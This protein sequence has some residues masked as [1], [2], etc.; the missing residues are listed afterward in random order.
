[1][2]HHELLARLL[3]P[4]SYDPNGPRIAAELQVEGTAL[5]RAH[6]NI[7]IA[8]DSLTPL[9]AVDML[10]DWERVCG[11]TPAADASRQK[12]VDAVVAKLAEIGGLSIPYF[13]NLGASLG[14]EIEIT[15]YAPFYLDYSHLDVDRLH[16]WDSIWIWQVSVKGGNVR[17][18][19][20]VLDSSA[21]DESFLSFS[22]AVIENVFNDLKPAHTLVVFDYEDSD[23]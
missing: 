12:R 6:A 3:P 5:D 16:P 22:D 1:M 11:L 10:A 13:L 18:Y 21:L 9:Y 17:A 15:E 8:I 7:Q 4:I 23:K 2:K 19:P 14:Y 20:F